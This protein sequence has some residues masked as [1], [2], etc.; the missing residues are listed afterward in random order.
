M[1][2]HPFN[3]KEHRWEDRIRKP[4]DKWYANNQMHW[5]I[6]KGERAEVGDLR[7]LDVRHDIPAGIFDPGVK[8]FTTELFYSAAEVPARRKDDSKF[9]LSVRR[10]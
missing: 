4:D 7:E 2:S 3:E 10:S 5:F 8:Q 1:V 6:R 9:L